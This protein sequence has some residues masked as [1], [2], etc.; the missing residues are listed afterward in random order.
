MFEYLELV[1]D[2]FRLLLE[3]HPLLKLHESGSTV[4]G[5]KILARAKVP[6]L[7]RLS[8]RPDAC[9]VYSATYAFS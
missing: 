7:A 5:N 4:V 2:P 1:V 9:T 8:E 6:Y 3:E